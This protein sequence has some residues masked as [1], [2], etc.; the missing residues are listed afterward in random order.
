ML[1]SLLVPLDG[2]LLAEQATMPTGEIAR[3]QEARL[4]LATV[5]PWGPMEDAPKPGTAAD[6]ELGQTETAYLESFRNR[7]SVAFGIHVGAYILDNP[8]GAHVPCWTRARSAGI[9]CGVRDERG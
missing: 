9:S 3:R 1:R 7:L 2:S 4:I 6:R 8:A 5:H